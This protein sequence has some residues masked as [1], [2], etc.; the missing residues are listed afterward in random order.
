MKKLLTLILTVILGVMAIGCFT[1]CGNSE[2]A[3]KKVVLGFDAEFP[4]YGYLDTETNKY[5][6]FD[7]ELAQ[8]VC[9][10]LGYELVLNPINWDFKDSLLESGTI[11]MIWNGFTYEGREDGYTWSDKYIASSIVVLTNKSEIS[12][13]DDLAGKNVVVQK[14]SSG[15]EALKAQPTLTA[16]FGSLSKEGDY[17]TAY[18]KLLAGTYDAIVI[19]IGVAKKYQSTDSSLKI[20]S[21]NIK[22]ENYAVGFKKGNT[23]L[24]KAINDKLN[25]VSKD[26]TFIKNLC[27]K[28]GIEYDSYLLG[29]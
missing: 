13:L 26:T 27:N 24:C 15:E 7:I 3:K 16:T 28:Y 10:E 29:K 22:T 5:V 20:L 4:P 12:S 18:Q 11:D 23:E 6:G 14:E 17:N 8:K 19:D 25:E 9:D 2:T 21:E 1:G